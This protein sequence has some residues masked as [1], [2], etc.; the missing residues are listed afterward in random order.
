MEVRRLAVV[1]TGLIGASVAL[2]AKHAGLRHVVGY[3]PEPHALAAAVARG[4]VDSGAHSLAEAVA[5]AE[6]AVVAAP[7]AQLAPEVRAVLE[8]SRGDCTVTDVGSTQVGVCSRA[9]LPPPPPRSRLLPLRRPPPG[10]RRG[11]G[12]GGE[13]ECGA[14]RRGDVVSDP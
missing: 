4:A 14:L 1:G 13:R 8:A 11:A 6:L 3:D 12:G 5:D 10:G 2:A 7:V 9:A